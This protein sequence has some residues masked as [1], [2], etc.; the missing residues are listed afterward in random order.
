MGEVIVTRKNKRL[1]DAEDQK[2]KQRIAA[3]SNGALGWLLRFV[4]TDLNNLSQGQWSDLIAEC[5]VFARGQVHYD[6]A[7][8]RSLPVQ[9]ACMWKSTV[10]DLA[11]KETAVT[12]LSP[13]P[14][15]IQAL[16]DLLRKAL[17]EHFDGPLLMQF[18]L[19]KDIIVLARRSS[20]SRKR[21]TREAGGR[22]ES[23]GMEA[24]TLNDAFY[25]HAAMLLISFS[26]KIRRC[27]DCQTIFPAVRV[28]QV[29][30][31][32]ACLNRNKQQRHRER[33]K[34]H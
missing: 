34:T 18:P 10:L 3:V 15:A 13:K 33:L 11:G 27:E 28:D 21:A 24:K 19:P 9:N 4:Q 20:H 31:S 22:S 8:L 6:G 30:C 7:V 25:F 16:Q 1:L 5:Q 26:E 29:F 14:S 17:K 2:A 32:P 23:A 12:E